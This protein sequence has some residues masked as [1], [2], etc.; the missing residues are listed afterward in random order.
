MEYSCCNAEWMVV[1]VIGKADVTAVV[2]GIGFVLADW[3]Y[4]SL[5]WDDT[6]RIQR[7][8][9]RTNRRTNQSS[10][11]DYTRSGPIP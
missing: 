2:V 4:L 6:Q 9:Q 8:Q 5:V 11:R 7:K 1:V 10:T 3:D